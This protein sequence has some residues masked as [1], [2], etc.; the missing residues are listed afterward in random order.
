MWLS[1]WFKKKKEKKKLKLTAVREKRNSSWCS[2]PGTHDAAI[3]SLSEWLWG[4][5]FLKKKKKKKCLV[6]G[7]EHFYYYSIRTTLTLNDTCASFAVAS[8]PADACFFCCFFL[9]NLS[10][11]RGGQ[12]VSEHWTRSER[13]IKA[14]GA[15]WLIHSSENFPLLL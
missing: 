8:L 4:C 10:R 12:L 5:W 14:S 6:K 11:Q 9:E 1:S 2:A 13:W 3:V 7:F 15:A